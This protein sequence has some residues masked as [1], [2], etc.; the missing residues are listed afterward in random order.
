MSANIAV[1]V[2][3]GL[4]CAKEEERPGI[5]ELCGAIHSG[6]LV[7]LWVHQGAIAQVQIVGYGGDREILAQPMRIPRFRAEYQATNM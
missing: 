4:W 7:H 5:R 3:E 6:H 2:V 1:V